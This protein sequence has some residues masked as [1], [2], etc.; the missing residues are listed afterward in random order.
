VPVAILCAVILTFGRLSADNELIAVRS[1]GVWPDR[2]TIP[3]VGFGLLMSVA[4]FWLFHWAMPG[5]NRQVEEQKDKM[6]KLLIRQ[7]GMFQK[8][9]DVPPY[10]I[11]VRA[12]DPDTQEWCDVA[13]VRLVG[14]FVQQ[15]TRASRGLCLVDED[16]EAARIELKDC[17]VLQPEVGAEKLPVGLHAQRIVLEVDLSSRRRRDSPDRP[18]V[19][20]LPDL[21][22]NMERLREEA[23]RLPPV[24]RP[25]SE[26]RDA[27]DRM[28]AAHRKLGTAA[29]ERAGH[30]KEM[31]KVEK[32]VEAAS[33]E[34][35]R[36][37]ESEAACRS[38][39]ASVQ[40]QA[41]RLR[42]EAKTLEAERG[43]K[44]D[45][46]RLRQVAE[47]EAAVKAAVAELAGR[48]RV[49]SG[50]IA[51]LA[52]ESAA[53]ADAAVRGRERLDEMRARDAEF[54]AR[55]ADLQRELDTH[56]A[57]HRVARSHEV[58]ANA[59][60]EFH[61]R[62]TSAA[63]CL[64]FTLIGIPLGILARRGNVIYAFAFSFGLM[65]LIYHPLLM[66]VQLLTRDRFVPMTAAFWTPPALVGGLGIWLL[67]F[68]VRR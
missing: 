2:L 25:Q 36:L 35:R 59:E 38:D 24:S 32:E 27:Q 30:A 29:H 65:I 21:W 31:A 16:R 40:E 9:F 42:S 23:S 41:A 43:R 37:S 44:P 52:R 4:G 63:S 62:N 8:R 53:A 39:L 45:E 68:K 18:A 56:L 12:V 49:L 46:A 58:L 60:A 67:F 1:S 10:Q 48:E 55:Q 22:R 47:R 61:T 64:V 14:D 17:I 28:Y 19:W 26:R 20:Q 57:A 33:A 7:V 54:A 66:V 3:V 15:I 5:A 34:T 13:V 51:P 50:R 6:Y 11:Y